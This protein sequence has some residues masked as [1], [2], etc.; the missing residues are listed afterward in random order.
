MQPGPA[1]IRF[2]AGRK[3]ATSQAIAQMAA[4]GPGKACSRLRAVTQVRAAHALRP[5]EAR[6]S[7]GTSQHWHS[8]L[9]ARGL[10]KGDDW[11]CEMSQ[12]RSYRKGKRERH[13]ARSDPAAKTHL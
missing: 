1:N 2:S 8:A 4:N 9:H 6:R 11:H 3:R 5:D 12:S 13:S 7:T 10:N